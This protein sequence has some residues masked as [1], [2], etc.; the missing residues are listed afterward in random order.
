MVV[1]NSR[2][3]RPFTIVNMDIKDVKNLKTL[4]NILV[5]EKTYEESKPKIPFKKITIL[6]ILCFDFHIR[7]MKLGLRCVFMKRNLNGLRKPHLTSADMLKSLMK[8][9]S[10]I[11]PC[12]R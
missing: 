7:R 2:V 8:N 3:K 4:I 12:G 1:R 11:Y 10:T 6:A 5:K 9:L